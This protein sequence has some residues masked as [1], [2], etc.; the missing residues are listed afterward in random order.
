MVF[1]PDYGDRLELLLVVFPPIPPFLCNTITYLVE[2]ETWPFK[3][4]LMCFLEE[5]KKVW[6]WFVVWGLLCLTKHYF[7]DHNEVN[8]Y[9]SNRRTIFF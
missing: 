1:I 7:K 6:G 5:K 4:V 9:L 3:C 8:D 2:N